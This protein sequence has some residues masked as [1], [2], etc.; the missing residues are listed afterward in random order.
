MPFIQARADEFLVTSRA[1]R[2]TN[3]GMG[4]SALVRPGT[5]WVKVSGAKQEACFAMTQ[6]SRDGIPLRFKG[7]VIYR[8]DDPLTVL[9]S[10]RFAGDDGDRRMRE[11]L[12]DV[13][14]GELRDV[15]SHM[16]MKA[17]IEERKTTLTD[18]AGQVELS[19]AVVS[20]LPWRPV[21]FSNPPDPGSRRPRASRSGSR[22]GAGP[23]TVVAPS[24]EWRRAAPGCRYY[25]LL[26]RACDDHVSAG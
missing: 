16:T 14:L 15:V 2:L 13:C 24:H 3:R 21:G 7:F 6:E 22:A 4:R 25:N 8:A 5:T 19:T 10:F 1:G 23:F 12:A 18:A 26:G 9:R 17:C 11:L 20:S